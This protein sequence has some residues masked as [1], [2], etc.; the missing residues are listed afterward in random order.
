ML[1]LSP[2]LNYKSTRTCVYIREV[3]FQIGE[4][5]LKSNNEATLL[6]LRLLRHKVNRVLMYI[7]T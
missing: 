6:T 2:L 4:L 5:R 1:C 3:D 7:L